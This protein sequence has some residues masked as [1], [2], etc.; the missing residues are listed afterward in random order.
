MLPAHMRE[1][2]PN[3]NI[4]GGLIALGP[5]DRDLLPRYQRRLN[6]FS[7]ARSV[8]NTRYGNRG[9]LVDACFGGSGQNTFVSCP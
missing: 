2:A 4:A 8:D 1:N 3:L 7:H 9:A 6:D 5:L